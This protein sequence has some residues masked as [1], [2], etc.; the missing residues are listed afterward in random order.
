MESFC[1]VYFSRYSL[2]LCL[3]A[4]TLPAFCMEDSRAKPCTSVYG[5]TDANLHQT[6]KNSK[7]R[8]SR[9][10]NC[11][12]QQSVYSQGFTLPNKLF[13]RKVQPKQKMNRQCG[14]SML[15]N[16]HST[17]TTLGIM[18]PSLHKWPH[19]CF[20]VFGP[21]KQLK[22]K[23]NTVSFKVH[24]SLKKH[25]KSAGKSQLSECPH[26]VT[27]NCHAL[28][29]FNEIYSWK[30]PS[31]QFKTFYISVLPIVLSSRVITT[32]HFLLKVIMGEI[33]LYISPDSEWRMTWAWG[34]VVGKILS[35]IFKYSD[36]LTGWGKKSTQHW[37]LTEK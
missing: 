10:E 23:N 15:N 31:I 11:S 26:F 4:H 30:T 8:H 32:D 14:F 35:L 24:L 34:L 36:C 21:H 7:T 16:V 29:P 2:F 1:Y 25:W 18:T 3:S 37:I 33:I 5:M 22:L 17:S 19:F 28:L 6:W 12:A 20:T 13:H 27:V 9:Q